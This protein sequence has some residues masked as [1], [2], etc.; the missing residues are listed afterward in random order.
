VLR[1]LQLNN[2]R[3][4]RGP[5]NRTSG[6]TLPWA[7]TNL[8]IAASHIEMNTSGDTERTHRLLTLWLDLQRAVNQS[9]EARVPWDSKDSAVAELWK[10]ITHP[11][12]SHALEQWL[13]Q[14]ADGQPAEWARQALQSCRKRQ[15][16]S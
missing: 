3:N 6:W 4:V 12:N 1:R 16:E 15:G 14:S 5:N 2:K 10:K 11:A 13:Y 9:K 8:A 7:G